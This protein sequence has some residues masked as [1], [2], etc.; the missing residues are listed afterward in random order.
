MSAETFYWHD[1][2]TFGIDPRRDRPVQFAGIRTNADFEP[3]GEPLVVFLRPPFDYLPQ[4][5]ACLITGITPQFA[6][7]KGLN[8][9]EFSRRIFNEIAIAKTCTL[10]YNSL[11]FDDEF[12][13]NLLYRNFFD[14]YVREWQGGNSRWDIIDVVRAARALRPEGINW[15][16]NDDG[17]PSTRLEHLTAANNIVHGHAHDALSDVLATI[18]I[19]K[20]IKR[21]QP[22]LFQFLLQHRFKPSALDLLKVGRYEPL[23]HVSG[24]YPSVRQCTAVVLPLCA[25]PVNSNGVIVYDLSVD[26]AALLELP[27][28]EIR[29]RLFTP[30]Q[31]LAEGID[32]IP[33]KTVHVNKCPVLAPLSVIRPSDIERLQLD[34]VVCMTHKDKI[35]AAKGL[36]N[37]L[38]DVFSVPKIGAN[39]NDPDLM[40]Y[41]G[42]FLGDSDKKKIAQ[43]RARTPESLAGT[44][45]QFSDPRLSEMLFRYRARNYPESLNVFEQKIWHEFCLRRLT[46]RQPEYGMSFDDYFNRIRELQNE[47]QADRSI[48]EQL[49]IYGRQKMQQLGIGE[50]SQFS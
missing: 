1:Y 7:R 9:A 36:N 19:A 5:D 28:D 39:E 26:P 13:R 30:T 44:R 27:A 45:Y 43:I 47:Q 24:R 23:V 18:D 15:P 49:E 25:H 2:E 31:Q 10:G 42:G 32:R 33:L 6:E 37:K 21:A 16:C 11:R 22:R 17:S 40:I 34:L 50:S 46:S 41:S 12:T 48:L 3:I 38:T 14:P 20:L 35:V 29:N 8:E 4:P